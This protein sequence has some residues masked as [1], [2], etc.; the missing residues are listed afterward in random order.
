MA[1]AQRASFQEKAVHVIRAVRRA[2]L[3]PAE[4]VTESIME[5]QALEEPRL[6][7]TCVDGGVHS[8]LQEVARL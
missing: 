8:H 2:K 3:L 6:W 7:E 1:P 4:G 5:K